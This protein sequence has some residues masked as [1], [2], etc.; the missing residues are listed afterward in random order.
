MPAMGWHSA[1]AKGQ[2]VNIS[3][4]GGQLLN[5]VNTAYSSKEATCRYSRSSDK[6]VFIKQSQ[7]KRE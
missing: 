6:Y 5:S 3:S 1:P 7:N 4:T 2:G